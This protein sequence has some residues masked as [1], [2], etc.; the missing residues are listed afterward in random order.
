[1]STT[2]ATVLCSHNSSGLLDYLKVYPTIAA[3]DELVWTFHDIAQTHPSSVDRIAKT[4]VTIK[5]A[6][7]AP[8]IATYDSTGKPITQPLYDLLV[9]HVFDMLTS[10][11]D[12]PDD[13]SIHAENPFILAAVTSGACS[14]VGLCHSAV[15]ASM[16]TRGLHCEDSAYKEYFP[17]E[18]YEIRAIHACLHLLVGA[19]TFVTT[20]QMGY[21]K[22][23]ILP[24]LNSIAQKNII[25]NVNGKK[26]LQVRQKY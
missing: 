13:L 5:D 17:P 24:A 9:R 7:D 20:D 6:P 16:V 21:D 1:M 15:Q 19:S 26:L 11:F 2:L 4:I 12:D 10:T 3:V 23:K 18:Q 14:R 8:D 25:S 22:D